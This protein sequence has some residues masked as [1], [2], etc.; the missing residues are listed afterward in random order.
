MNYLETL[1]MAN[2]YEIN[3]I[4]LIIGEEVKFFFDSLKIKYDSNIVEQDIFNAICES[5]YRLYLKYDLEMSDIIKAFKN[6]YKYVEDDLGKRVKNI[7][8]LPKTNYFDEIRKYI[9]KN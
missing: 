2:R 4:K 1:Q 6:F 7:T 8:E 5:I 3:S 9:I